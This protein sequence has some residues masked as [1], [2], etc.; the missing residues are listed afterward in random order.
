MENNASPARMMVDH[1]GRP[2]WKALILM[3]QRTHF[4]TH[5]SPKNTIEFETSIN[6]L[7]TSYQTLG[8]S[9]IKSPIMIKIFQLIDSKF[10]L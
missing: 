7:I 1:P 9:K 10:I 8:S 6:S 4:A 2:K 3:T 5:W